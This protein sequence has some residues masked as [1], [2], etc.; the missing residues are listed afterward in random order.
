MDENTER[1]Q[2]DT[3]P[4]EVEAQEFDPDEVEDDPSQ[5]PPV[6]GLQD[7]KGGERQRATRR[8]EAIGG[9]SVSRPVGGGER[10]SQPGGMTHKAGSERDSNAGRGP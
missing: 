10:V 7:L 2:A 5:A 4:E 6:D 8:V 1:D 9:G 3:D